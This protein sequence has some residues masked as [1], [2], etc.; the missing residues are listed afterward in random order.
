[1]RKLVFILLPLFFLV[2][3]DS[4]FVT[5]KHDYSF[6]NDSSFD[7]ELD[8]DDDIYT[9][10]K[11]ETLEI[12]LRATT[13]ISINDNNRVLLDHS[14]KGNYTIIDKSH[15]IVTVYN[16]SLQDILLYEKDNYIGS[17]AMLEAAK[18]NNQNVSIELHADSTQT[19]ELY[20]DTP[21]YYAY[22]KDNNMPAD[23]A[24]LSFRF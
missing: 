22:F 19:F 13:P 10:K 20:T 12:K 8:I 23:I 11:N 24:L 9:V 4:T 6:K 16:S 15:K 17:N 14:Y 1:M 18:S 2:A 21:N 3:C 5:G 7:V